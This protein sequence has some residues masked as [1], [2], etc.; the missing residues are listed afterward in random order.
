MKR[1]L[2]D[3]HHSSLL[4]SLVTLFEDRLGYK[5]FRPIGL[6]W[7]VEGYWKINN[8][9]DTAKQYL[10]LEQV[11]RDGTPKLNRIKDN[12]RGIY[13]CY[14]GGSK[15]VNRACTLEYAKHYKF[16]YLVA[17]IPAHIPVFER[18]IRNYQPQAKLIVQIGNEWPLEL[19]KGHN[20][21]ASVK[22]RDFPDTNAMFYHQEFD[23]KMF[24]P[25]FEPRPKKIYTFVN[26]LQDKPRDYNLF[27]ELERLMPTWEF[28]MYGGQNRD[29]NIDG[30][31][32]L[33]EK[34]REP[35]YLFHCKTGG[36]GY[37][38]I[39]FNGAFSATPLITRFED[40]GNKLG[41]SLIYDESS[42][43]VD[44]KTP[45]QIA[46]EIEESY[47]N[48]QYLKRGKSIYDLATTHCNFTNEA[49]SIEKWLT[50][51]R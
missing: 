51:L 32:A 15:L 27:L 1:V 6:Q 21:L 31:E 23:L 47:Y 7:Y 35:A 39:L 8:Q 14:D 37:G 19:F 10:S 28:K 3:F 30:P 33:A 38:H 49:E 29:G 44:N 22:P 24:K 48:E 16:D 18:I 41:E 20:V 9:Y 42:I 45:K 40:Y 13:Y 50:S 2:V 26:V 25:N 43:I 12:Q 5:V 4:R 46:A 11:P 36:D 34:M 17:T